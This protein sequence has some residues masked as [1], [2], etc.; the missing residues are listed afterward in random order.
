[1]LTKKLAI[2]TIG[3]AFL[4]G[5]LVVPT[6]S[7]HGGRHHYAGHRWEQAEHRHHHKHRHPRK[8][9]HVHRHAPARRHH[10]DTVVIYDDAA[11]V[12]LGR[13]NEIS[14]LYRGAW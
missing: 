2:S 8:V 6:A 10:P 13:G 7:A 12:R 3:A 14:I 1:M 5:A 4:A 11:P 9:V